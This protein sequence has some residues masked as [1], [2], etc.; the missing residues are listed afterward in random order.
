MLPELSVIS[1]RNGKRINSIQCFIT[2]GV[3][4]SQV[5]TDLIQQ[6]QKSNFKLPLGYRIE[7]GGESTTRD[8]TVANLMA[9]VGIVLVLM[10]ATLVL[11]FSSFRLAFII[12]VVG[13]CSV[14]LG[15]LP[16]WI[17]GYPLGFM[18]IVGTVSLIGVAINDSIV[19][20]AA[21]QGDSQASLGN[22]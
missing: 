14:G 3:L 21:S 10:L 19:V 11:S 8:E 4:P 6:L 2:A 20:L 17:F 7:F 9:T 1:R 13:F 18:A 5:L 15:L 16:L 22:I 12:A